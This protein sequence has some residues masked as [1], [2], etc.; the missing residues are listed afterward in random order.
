MCI[1]IYIYHP[2][3]PLY[4]LTKTKHFCGL[5]LLK[6]QPET[7]F[8]LTIFGFELIHKGI[9]HLIIQG[10]SDEMLF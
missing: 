5:F 9:A 8:T 3:R 6:E 1:C 7:F 10:D 4:P 2:F